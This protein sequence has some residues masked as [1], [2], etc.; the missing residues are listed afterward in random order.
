MYFSKKP[1][2][3]VKTRTHLTGEETNPFEKEH[4]AAFLRD[5]LRRAGVYVVRGTVTSQ[6]QSRASGQRLGIRSL[7]T[8]STDLVISP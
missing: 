7:G 3:M 6:E 4:Q 1:D 2:N 8:F 5:S